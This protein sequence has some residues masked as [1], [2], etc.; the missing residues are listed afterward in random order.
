MTEYKDFEPFF[1]AMIGKMRMHDHH[2]GDSWKREEKF[3]AHNL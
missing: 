3:I 1:K 2:K